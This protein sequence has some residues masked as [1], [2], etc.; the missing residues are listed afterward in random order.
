MNENT[1][2]P[3]S[4]KI[5]IKEHPEA[6]TTHPNEV[7]EAQAMPRRSRLSKAGIRKSRNTMILSILGII[8]ILFLLFRY[9]IPLISDASFLFG[10]VTSVPEDN[11]E[12]KNETFVPVPRLDSLPKATKEESVKVTGKSISGLDILIYVNG[13]M[14][15]EVST[16]TEG[17]FESVVELSS[18]ENLIKAKAKKNE[19]TSDFSKTVSITVKKEGPELTIDSPSD[20]SNINGANPIEVKGKTDPDANVIV[21]D[22]QAITN[23]R[24][25]WS[26]YLTL[27]GGDNEIKVTS[28]DAAGNK[29]EKTIRVNYSQ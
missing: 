25:E 16:D 29:T 3:E 17:D 12:E 10:K 18:G 2:S 4:D 11:E 9:G 20:G 21:N 27:K 6:S 7:S 26:Y 5:E 28:T 23:S 14:V 1:M 24:G 19:T 13:D 15:N 8:A 22:F